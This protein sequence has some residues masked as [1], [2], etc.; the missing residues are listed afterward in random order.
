MPSNLANQLLARTLPRAQAQTPTPNPFRLAGF[1]LPSLQIKATN[2]LLQTSPTPNISS[3]N[4]G[5]TTL[6]PPPSTRTPT[7]QIPV[8]ARLHPLKTTVSGPRPRT[9]PLPSH[10][11]PSVHHVRPN[12]HRGTPLTKTSSPY[13]VLPISLPQALSRS[14]SW[15]LR[16]SM[17]TSPPSIPQPSR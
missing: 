14:P 11:N 8:S 2:H 6:P 7:S 12:P 1:R 16:S 5:Q 17:A 3:L 13:S 4:M 15:V 9:L 10:L